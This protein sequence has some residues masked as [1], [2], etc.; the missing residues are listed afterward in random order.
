MTAITIE[1]L[2]IILLIAG[3]GLLAMSEFAIA[4]ARKARL[5]NLAERGDARARVALELAD[6]PNQFLS[7]VQI[8]ITLVG[9]LAG[10]FGGATLAEQLA[11]RLEVIEPLA[12]YSEAIAVAVVV[13]AITYLSLVF[14]ELVPKRLA[15]SNS[16]RV[17]SAVARPMRLLSV[18]AAPA[19][20]LLSF[21]TDTVL[22]LLG[23]KPSGEPPVTEDEIKVLIRQGTVAGVFEEAEEDLVQNVF[24]LGDRRVRA[25]MTPRHEIVC[26]DIDDPPELNQRRVAESAHSRF[27]VCQGSIDKLSGIVRA[28]DLLVQ[29]MSGGPFDLRAIMR[30]P[31]FIPDSM[32][33]LTVLE[34]FKQTGRHLALVIDEHGGIEGLITH[35]DILSAL[36][37]NIPMVDELV[38]LQ[39]VQR[40]DGSW[41]IDGALLI[42]ELKDLYD[43]KRLPGEEEETFQT[44]G[45]FVMWYLGRVPSIG[46]HFEWNG[47]RFE[48]LDMDRRRIDKVLVTPL[49][50][51][52]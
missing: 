24:R 36:V 10:A 29:Q 31:L 11:G 9:I 33:A 2:F 50:K 34:E 16:E 39:I 32:R 17:A 23:V 49:K 40:E 45:G 44:V 15:L 26:L 27:P 43:L 25:L 52:Q 6:E 30:P 7:T 51:E 22:R 35:H 47:L 4:S 18:I 42:D 37:G 14:G 20:R 19:V 41:L 21:S 1:I 28:K 8:G 48:V 38:E 13:L 46:E 12:P 3:N 5:Q